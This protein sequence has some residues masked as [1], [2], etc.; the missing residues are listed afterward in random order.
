[1]VLQTVRMNQNGNL[2]DSKTVPNELRVHH[3]Q[4]P[5]LY[6]NLLFEPFLNPQ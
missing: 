2:K 3:Y 4:Q 5:F 6:D 1:M